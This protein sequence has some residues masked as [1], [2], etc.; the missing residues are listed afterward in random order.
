MPLEQ[1]DFASFTA[2]KTRTAAAAAIERLSTNFDRSA[3]E[4]VHG[5]GNEWSRTHYGGDFNLYVPPD[6]GT[7]LSLVFV[8]SKNGNTGAKDPS[9]L[10][11]GPTDEHLIY[12]GLSRV[13]ADAVLAGAGS[14]PRRSLFS[15]WHPELVA[16]RASL[17]LARHPAQIVVSKEGRRLDFTSLLFNVPDVTVFLIA[18]DACLSR[19]TPA[20][21]ERPWIRCAPIEGGG[22]RS[23][24]ERLRS[25]AGIRRI[26][27]IGGRFTASHLVDAGAAQDLYL[28]TASRDGGE[29][30]TPWYTGPAAP[31]LRTI[32]QKQWTHLGARILFE[33]ILIAR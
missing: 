19:H 8:Q 26:S 6:G 12:E 29:P 24:L 28:T 33:H 31:P 17:G 22:I 1:A 15:V 7:A 4:P 30:G 23:V 32:T 3:A 5:I 10:G 14:L 2:D 9:A 16:L 11:G 21:R 25:E 27:S 18:G 13:A 20:L